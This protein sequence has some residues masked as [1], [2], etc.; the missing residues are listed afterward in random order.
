MGFSVIDEIKVCPTVTRESTGRRESRERG[1]IRSGGVSF[2]K[3][4]VLLAAR[5]WD[6]FDNAAVAVVVRSSS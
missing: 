4:N 3:K 2:N 5:V 6:V 1:R